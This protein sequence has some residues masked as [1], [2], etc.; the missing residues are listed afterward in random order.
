MISFR[1]QLRAGELLAGTWIKTP[2]P[3]VVEVLSFSSLDCLVLD[4]E[5]APFDRA[6]LDLCILAARAGGKTVLV[7]P[8]SAS[9]EHILNAL[10]CGADGVILPHI[11][12]AADAEDAVKACHYIS[13]GRGYAGSSRAAGYTT[14]G[15][16]K[17]RADA[18]SVTIIVQ[19]E[20][21]EG[22]ENIDAIAAVSG[23]DALFIGRA[24][25]TI[26]YNAETPDD[27]VVVDA[28]DR[29]VTAGKAAS[30]A[31]GMFLGRVGDVGMWR[32]KGASL[33]ILG[34]DHDFLLQGAAKL[35]E[36]VKA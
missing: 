7:R 20:D 5:H 30:R 33:F 9:Q 11:C 23:I 1:D 31:T 17:H 18:A 13:G 4:A 32:E 3:H 19:I 10:D 8:Q 29:I 36:A 35:A 27:A 6:A 14:K 16:A 15:M 34:S 26:A 12:N 25:L 28:V 22:V 21:V 24:D 2:H